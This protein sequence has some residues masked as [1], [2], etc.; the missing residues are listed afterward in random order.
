MSFYA[1]AGTT[2]AINWDDNFDYS[3]V[4]Y[5]NPGDIQ[6]GAYLE[7]KTTRVSG[8]ASDLDSGYSTTRNI[9]VASSQ[10]VYLRIVPFGNNPAYVGSFAV[11]VAQ[12]GST[13]EGL[14]FR[15][16]RNGQA[17]VGATDYAYTV[18]LAALASGS[19]TFTAIGAREGVSFS[20]AFD[21]TK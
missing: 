4:A 13:N 21:I 19:Y 10:T 1:V 20:D 12:V 17:L 11:R 8:W 16:M 7:N 6:V 5:I 14:S 15:W 9:S 18:S 2:Y 3:D